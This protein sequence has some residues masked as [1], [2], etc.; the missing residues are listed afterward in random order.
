M[1]EKLLKL[2]SFL[3]RKFN[4][5]IDQRTVEFKELYEEKHQQTP[6]D[7]RIKTFRKDYILKQSVTTFLIVSFLLFV[8][9]T[10]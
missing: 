5:Y 1:K 9:T 3:T 7:A 10:S 8:F 4:D 6:S 2:Y